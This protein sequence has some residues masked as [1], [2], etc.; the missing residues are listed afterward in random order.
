MCCCCGTNRPTGRT[1]KKSLSARGCKDYF[2][3]CLIEWYR[4]EAALSRSNMYCSCGTSRPTGR[5]RKKS[6]I[7][8]VRTIFSAIWHTEVVG[9]SWTKDRLVSIGVRLQLVDHALRFGNTTIIT[10]KTNLVLT[11]VCYN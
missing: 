7:E 2:L 11:H 9:A 5:T 6:L 1:R 8:V 10:M 3:Q 4:L